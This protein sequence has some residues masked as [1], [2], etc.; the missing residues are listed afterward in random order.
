[1]KAILTLAATAVLGMSTTAMAVD[2]APAVVYD[3][4]GKFDKSFNE[5]V[6]RGGAEKFAADKGIR[7]REFE[8]QNEEQREQGLRRL[9]SRGQ[10]PIVA[11]G[12][13]MTSALKKVAVEFPETQFVLIDDVLDLPNVESIT[14]AEHEGSFLVGALAALKS[15]TD[16]VGFVGG[17]DVGLIHKFGCGYIQG[18]KYLKPE[19]TVYNEMIAADFSGFND[20]AGGSELA[21]SQISKGADVI[22]AAAGG[23]G[24]GVYQAAKDAGIYAIGVDSNQNYLL[25]GTMLTSM[26]K[27]VGN[28]TYQSWEQAEAGTWTAGHKVL[29]LADGGIDYALDEY[30]E[31]LLTPEM[32]SQIET[33]KAD[34][35]SGKIKVH[36]YTS[37]DSCD[38]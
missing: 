19:G 32:K 4:A 3:T 7:V 33:I 37:N 23:S 29:G 11:V 18:F 34:I 13:Q 24:M 35:V 26:L 21:K 8:P 6:F 17:V 12:F 5:A 15:E 27:K 25:P 30:N 36:D 14:F 2:F 9:A 22:F 31:S 28:A 38:Y 20:P 16:K 10:S 1:M